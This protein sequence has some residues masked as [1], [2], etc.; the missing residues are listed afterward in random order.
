MLDPRIEVIRAAYGLGKDDFWKLPQGRDVWLVKHAALETVAAKAGISFDM[1]QIIEA[2]G[3]NG[4]AAVCVRGTYQNRSIWSIGEA[5]PKNCKNAYPWAIAEK[6]AIDRV[7]LK[8]IGIH[9]LVYSEEE[10]DD[11]KQV[12]KSETYDNPPRS[13][14]F[15]KPKRTSSAQLKRDQVWPQMLHDISE[16]LSEVSLNACRRVWSQQAAR[17]HWPPDWCDAAAEEFDKAEAVLR[18]RA[19][20][21]NNDLILDEEPIIFNPLGA[22]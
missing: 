17:D 1:P 16:C 15:D 19:K 12:L 4:I 20:E 2:D 6:R 9:G 7:I 18:R 14:A 22:G 11:F 21:E 8:L 5:S 3:G 13:K 10:S